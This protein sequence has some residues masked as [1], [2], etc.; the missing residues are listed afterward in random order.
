MF[1]DFYEKNIYKKF[2]KKTTP[3]EKKEVVNNTGD[4]FPEKHENKIKGMEDVIANYNHTGDEQPTNNTTERK[5]ATS[6]YSQ[7]DC[8]V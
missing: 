4:W 7:K 6:G 8:E 2:Y 3:E 5:E 1:K